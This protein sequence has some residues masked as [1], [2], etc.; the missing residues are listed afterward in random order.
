MRKM[1]PLEQT[2]V[3]VKSGKEIPEAVELFKKAFPRMKEGYTFVSKEYEMFPPS[4]WDWNRGALGKTFFVVYISDD[5][6]IEWATIQEGQEKV[7]FNR[8]G[9]WKTEWLDDIKHPENK[10]W[11]IDFTNFHA[12]EVSR[13]GIKFPWRESVFPLEIVKNLIAAKKK[14]QA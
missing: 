2:Y 1:H 12:A 8:P 7:N 6:D 11:R 13:R 4:K 3:K 9:C 10:T 14:T 5:R